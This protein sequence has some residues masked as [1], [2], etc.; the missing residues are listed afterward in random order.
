MRLHPHFKRFAA[1]FAACVI[2]FPFLVQPGWSQTEPPAMLP[3]PFVEQ[4]LLEWQAQL[5]ALEQLQAQQAATLQAIELSRTEI[6]TAAARS[7]DLTL[8]RLDTMHDA[9]AAQREHDLEFIR[10]SNRRVLTMVSGLV[11]LLFLGILLVTLVSTRAMNRL[12]VALSSLPFAQS[13]LNAST[14]AGLLTES[15]AAHLQ[16]AIERLEQRIAGLE[17][18][19]GNQPPPESHETKD[20]SDELLAEPRP[21]HT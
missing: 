18:H 4:L 8:A 10:N 3:D 19:S 21:A 15:G 17:S 14:P 9:L 2:L 16:N 1:G 6:A 7:V 13:Q 5:A 20:H 11:G 12:T